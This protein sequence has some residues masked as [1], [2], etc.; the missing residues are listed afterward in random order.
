MNDAAR[1]ARPTADAGLGFA[2]DALV[3]VTVDDDRG[4]VGVEDRE[5]PGRHGDARRDGLERALAVLSDL[6]VRDVAHVE[7]MIGVG[8]GVAR[9]S[10]IEVAAGG[11][12]VRL[13]LADRVQVYAMQSG[14]ESA[15]RHGDVDDDAGALLALDE[16]DLAGDAVAFDI[17]VRARAALCHRDRARQR[18][19]GSRQQH[20]SVHHHLHVS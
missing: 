1:D 9:R 2:G 5:G 16:L 4:T 20:S 14:L 10:W 18:Q 6:E 19:R 8:V 13:T 17:G 12:E 15:R 3:L 11:G 7:R